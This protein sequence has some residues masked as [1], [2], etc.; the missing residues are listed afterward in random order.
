MAVFS[1]S[2]NNYLYKREKKSDDLAHNVYRLMNQEKSQIN[3]LEFRRG[4]V[5]WV[6]EGQMA[7]ENTHGF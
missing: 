1:N 6:F 5:L 4:E 2:I 3:T 7:H